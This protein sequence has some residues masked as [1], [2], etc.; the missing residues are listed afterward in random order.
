M[1]HLDTTAAPITDPPEQVTFSPDQLLYSHTTDYYWPTI[2]ANATQ[3][4]GSWSAADGLGYGPLGF[5]SS[6][7]L[8]G[9]SVSRI[10]T[11]N[12]F[13]FERMFS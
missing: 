10:E 8:Q 11:R 3:I 2:N 1:P 6:V 5:G 4:I 12:K 13:K 9:N 7:K